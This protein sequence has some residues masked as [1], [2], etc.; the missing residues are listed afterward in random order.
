[1]FKKQVPASSTVT[2]SRSTMSGSI[3][4]HGP[5]VKKELRLELPTGDDTVKLGSL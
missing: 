3:S 2:S 1:M 5:V 4:S